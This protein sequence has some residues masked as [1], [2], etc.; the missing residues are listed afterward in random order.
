[1]KES[2]PKIVHYCWFGKK[3][4]PELIKRCIKSWREV[5]VDYEIKEWNEDNFDLS[6]NNYVKEAYKTGKYAFVSDYVRI[7]SLYHYGGIYLDTDVEVFKSFDDLL[8]HDSFWG[9]EQANY[10]ATST[11]GAKKQH[12][13]I[14][15][16]V[17]SYKNLDFIQS[18]GQ[19][20]EKTNVAIVT[21]LLEKK[22][23]K[24]S[25]TYQEIKGC[26]AFFS[27]DYFS[28]YD[29]INCYT[30]KTKNTYAMHHFYKSWLPVQTRVKSNIKKVLVK[31]IGRDILIKLRSNFKV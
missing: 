23:L 26:G 25:G 10:I 29:Y 31:I 15:T 2:I 12:P 3:E 20:N 16:F 7:H 18:D 30:M 24:R 5:L 9:F 11:I 19:L 28:P 22:G 14:K 21:E 8:H 4:K 13:F 1:M 6:I 17:D 27:Q